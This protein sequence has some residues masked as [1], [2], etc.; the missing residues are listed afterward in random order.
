M[1]S[2]PQSPIFSKRKPEFAHSSRFGH[3]IKEPKR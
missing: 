2:A 1:K 3:G